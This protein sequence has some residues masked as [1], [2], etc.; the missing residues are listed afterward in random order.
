LRNYA[1]HCGTPISNVRRAINEDTIID[2]KVDK[3]L[4]EHTGMQ[5]S[6][7]KELENIVEEFIDVGAAIKSVYNSIISMQNSIF[8]LMIEDEKDGVLKSA[9]NLM[10]FYNKYARDKGVL[11]LATDSDI[12]GL[13]KLQRAEPTKVNVKFTQVPHQLTKFVLENVSIEFI[14]KGRNVGQSKAFP[15]MFKA[16]SVI[17]I[18]KY[19][20]GERL[21]LHNGIKWIKVMESIGFEYKDGCDRYAAIY[22]PHGLSVSSYNEIGDRFKDK[23]KDVFKSDK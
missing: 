20:T 13:T 6:F 10:E 22:A 16:Q 9:Y 15:V 19:E 8:N 23:I 11:Y 7:R 17:E 18:P 21:V 14:F 1:Q 5:K 12:E 3:F 2:L 4:S